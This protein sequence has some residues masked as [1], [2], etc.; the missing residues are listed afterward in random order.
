MQLL[1]PL[2]NTTKLDIEGDKRINYY[3]SY[4]TFSNIHASKIKAI[5]S[6]GYTFDLVLIEDLIYFDGI[7]SRD[8]CIGGGD[9]DLY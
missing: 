1:L 7:I 4:E 2:C 3:S 5:S 6:Y 9:S 8:R